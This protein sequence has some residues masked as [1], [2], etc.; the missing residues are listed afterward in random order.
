[1]SNYEIPATGP[2]SPNPTARACISAF[3]PVGDAASELLTIL[4]GLGHGD[5]VV[6]LRSAEANGRSII[7]DG[8]E[9]TFNG[10]EYRWEVTPCPARQA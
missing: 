1:M 5:A 9:I 6:A 8:S 4:P 10:R 2:T 3:Q 7:A